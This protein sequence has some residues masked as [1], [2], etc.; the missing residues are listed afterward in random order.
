MR[1]LRLLSILA[2]ATT[3][4]VISCTKEGPEGPVGATGPQG[5]TGAT[6]GTGATGPTGPQGPAG[7]TG[8]QGPAGSANVIYSAWVTSPYN[9]RDTTIDGTCCRVRHID[10]PS[11][12]ASILNQG[13]MITYMRV[14]SIGP[15]LLPYTS[16]AGGATNQIEAIYNLQK[17]LVTRKTFGSCR[18]SAADPGTAPVLINLPQSLEYRYI[19][20]PGAISGGR[21]V[22]VGGT[23][24]TAEQIKAMPYEQVCRLFSIQP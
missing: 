18:F 3:F 10:A 16:D 24:Y 6:G 20:I 17:I 22:G 8:P 13:V 19:L 15:Y 7:P 21:T 11:L 14:G 9:S 5:P 23:N 12:S 2:L 4:I 1:K